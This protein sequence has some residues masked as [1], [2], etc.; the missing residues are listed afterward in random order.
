MVEYSKEEL[1]SLCE[2]L[3]ENLKEAIF[4][5]KTAKIIEQTTKKYNLKKEKVSGVAKYTGYVLLGLLPP[6]E[7]ANALEKELEIKAETA[8]NISQELNQLVFLPLKGTLELLYKDE[9]E[10]ENNK[11]IKN[12]GKRKDFSSL[13][14]DPY[15]E[16][17]E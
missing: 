4:S 16:P 1:W 11:E 6:N 9:Q 12:K 3:P 14:K 2:Q 13:T 8:E 7:L 15:R 10:K 17:I 5:A